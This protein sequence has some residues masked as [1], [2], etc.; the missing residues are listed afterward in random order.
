[1]GGAQC[2]VTALYCLAATPDCFLAPL[3]MDERQQFGGACP[4]HGGHR[5]SDKGFRPI[6]LGDYVDLE[7]PN[8]TARQ[9]VRD[10]WG[11]AHGRA[12]NRPATLPVSRNTVRAGAS[13]WATVLRAPCIE[14]FQSLI[15]NHRRFNR[16]Q[17]TGSKNID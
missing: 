3:A 12:A 10:K 8:W 9:K 5:G 6:S 7:L 14:D 4:H 17:A 16:Q 15:L 2:D 1:V 11:D 13:L